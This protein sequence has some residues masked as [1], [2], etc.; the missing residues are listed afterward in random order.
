MLSCAFAELR[1]SLVVAQQIDGRAR[2][3]R[4]VTHRHE[5]AATFGQELARM[6]VGSRNHRTSGRDGPIV[7]VT[8]E[9]DVAALAA[10]DLHESGFTQLA[11]ASWATCLAAALPQ[12]P[13][14]A[15]PADADAI[16]HLFFVHDRHQGNLDAARRYLAWEQG[17]IAQCS[18]EELA[19]FRLDLASG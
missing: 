16:D 12:Q 19:T 11:Q 13:T 7:L 5:Q 8:D 3:G 4:R 17:L 6:P 9:P 15:D 2:D 1:A 18:A 10:I 14:P